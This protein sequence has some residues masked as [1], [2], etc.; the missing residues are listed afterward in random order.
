MSQTVP[1]IIIKN[2]LI[3]DGTGKPGFEGDLFVDAGKMSTPG[4]GESFH[5]ARVI[6]GRGLVACP[7]F[8]D[9]HAHGEEQLLATP[10]AEAKIMQGITTMVGGNCGISA[11]PIKG[12]L[13]QMLKSVDIFSG[14]ANTWSSLE[15]LFSLIEE[16]GS[17]INLGVLIGNGALRA[18]LFGMESRKPSTDELNEMKLL[19]AEAMQQGALG[20]SS[21]LVYAPSSYSGSEELVE[22]AKVAAQ[23]GG[24]YASHV[25]GM[26]HQIFEAVEEAIKI[27]KLAGLPVQISHLNAGYPNWGK[28]QELIGLIEKARFAGQDVTCDTLLHDESVFS[29]GSLF[30]AWVNE[31]G[32]DRL[33]QRLGDPS[34]RQRI[35]EEIL[36]D[37]DRRG[38]SVAACLL[39]DGK[40]DKLWL[41]EPLR[42]N[43]I[44]LKQLA[45]MQGKADP[46][47]AFFDLLMEEKGKAR[48]ISQPYSQEDIDKI[49]QY[50]WCMPETDGQPV[51]PDGKLLPNHQREYGAFAHLL[52]SYV[53]ERGVIN[54]EEAIRKS[55]SLP[56][57]RMGLKDRGTLHPGDWADIVLFDPQK[58][59]EM[60]DALHLT[61]SPQGIEFVLV[62]GQVVVEHGKH[63]GAL[64][65]KILRRLNHGNV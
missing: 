52:G 35:R 7:G 22:L 33:L 38:G 13:Q 16:Q 9:I 29:G 59:N 43:H 12:V 19:L 42:L 65:G 44:N 3:V 56:A 60:G 40:W 21:G 54:L 30:P 39:Q 10:T 50:A 27:G 31:G 64:P 28:A 5:A 53:R 25:R 51:S 62:N 34:T 2:A 61:R 63:T 41:I 37:G 4:T 15:D 45:E 36:A 48:G 1:E 24:F 18:C 47:E 23:Y 32:V 55:T 26:A 46:F 11:A 20:L 17:A 14:V 49:L 8:I 58:I 6:D 57:W